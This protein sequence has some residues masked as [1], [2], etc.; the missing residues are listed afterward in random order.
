MS[1]AQYDIV[2]VNLD[3]TIGGEMKKT[4]PCAVLSP[5]EMNKHLR[6]VIIAPITSKSN[7]YPTR[8]E[9]SFQGQT[10]WIAL[11]QVRTIDKKRIWKQVATL[12]S[13]EITTIKQVLK[14]M[15]VD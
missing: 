5:N 7:P 3:P 15:L 4:R 10:N 8:I 1:V 11:E 6:T 9:I 2:I 14:E 12:A 13:A